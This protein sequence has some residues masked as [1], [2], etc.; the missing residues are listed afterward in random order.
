MH[1]AYRLKITLK[2]THPPIWR[3]VLA[4]EHFT[5]LQLHVLIQRA[6]GWEDKHWHEFILQGGPTA[7]CFMLPEVLEAF[8]RPDDDGDETTT[9]MREV[10][11]S[12][13]DRLVYL[14]DHG[15]CWVHEIRLEKIERAPADVALPTCLKGKWECPP[16]DSGGPLLFRSRE[17]MAAEAELADDD[18]A[19][20]ALEEIDDEDPAPFDREQA[21]RAIAAVDW[22][23]P[24]LGRDT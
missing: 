14:Y 19:L 12:P 7:R 22:D 11:A 9:L 4:P 21:N 17:R 6:M 5:L 20:D 8:D 1:T 2:R 18:E 23:D 16:E 24:D 3:R 10:L 13:G 15:D